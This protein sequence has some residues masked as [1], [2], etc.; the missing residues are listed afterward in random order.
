MPLPIILL[1]IL[2]ASAV[3]AATYAVESN[4]LRRVLLGRV[5][6][7]APEEGL[8]LQDAAEGATSRI[9]EWIRRHM[10]AAWSD[11]PE[12][13]DRLIHAGFD[14]VTA[15]AVYGAAWLASA[16]LVP[17]AALVVAPRSRPGLYVACFALALA[18]G[19]V[20]PRAV[21]DRLAQRRQ[22]RLRRGVPDALDLLVVCV[23]AG[24]SLDA[25][26][27]RVAKEMREL[28]PALAQEFLI[29]NR[30]VN[31]GMQRERAL[32]GL[33]VRT[34]LEELRGLTSNMI[35]SER[36]GT[37]IATVLRIYAEGLRRKRKQTAE[38][39][40][41]TAPL[42]MLFPLGFFIFPSI[43]VVVIGPALIKIYAMFHKINQ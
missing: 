31:A 16:F 13:S 40:A 28:H 8:R 4:R 17:A 18:I 38:K 39:K 10:P 34:G 26:I 7:A 32:H 27:L 6:D 9:A 22:E 21:L 23:E 30:R 36:W 24:V 37:S 3:G 43:F 42:K 29:V 1:I 25:A 33:A 35:Q 20:A 2:I 41:A 12:V 11:R 14:S 19:L 15:P 5:D